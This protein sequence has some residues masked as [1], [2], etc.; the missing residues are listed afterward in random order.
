MW[1]ELMILGLSVG[2]GVGISSVVANEAVYEFRR[3]YE[4]RRR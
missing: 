2:A 1:W 4:R 3:W